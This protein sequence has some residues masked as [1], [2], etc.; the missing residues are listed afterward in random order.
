MV[1]M[2]DVRHGLHP[3]KIVNQCLQSSKLDW[4]CGRIS[5]CDSLTLVNLLDA[6][7][8]CTMQYAV[9]FVGS[10]HGFEQPQFTVFD[11]EFCL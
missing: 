6:G 7:G 2:E 3:S 1:L 5:I 10:S 8:V 9:M 4:V 11:S